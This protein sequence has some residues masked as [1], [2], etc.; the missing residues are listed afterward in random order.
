MAML[1]SAIKWAM[2]C[3]PGLPLA[4]LAIALPSPIN[5]TGSKDDKMLVANDGSFSSGISSVVKVIVLLDL[6]PRNV[7]A[8]IGPARMMVGMAIINP[9]INTLAISA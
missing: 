2:F 1:G 9:Y 8:K 4:K 5:N 3:T 7:L 6:M